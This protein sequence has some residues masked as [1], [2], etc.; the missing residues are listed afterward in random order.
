M[1]TQLQR[2]LNP[3]TAGAVAGAVVD[4]RHPSDLR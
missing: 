2:D 1:A 3:D 4:A